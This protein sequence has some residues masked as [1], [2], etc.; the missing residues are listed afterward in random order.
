MKS[1]CVFREDVNS[2]IFSSNYDFN[3][4]TIDCVPTNKFCVKLPKYFYSEFQTPLLF[5]S[6][7]NESFYIMALQ[8][9][10]GLMATN[11]YDVGV[12]VVS[13]DEVNL[14]L[15]NNRSIKPKEVDMSSFNVFNYKKV[16]IGVYKTLVKQFDVE[17]NF[18]F[19]NV[20]EEDKKFLTDTGEV[21]TGLTVLNNVSEHG[22]ISSHIR[23][24]R[25]GYDGILLDDDCIQRRY[26]IKQNKVV[27]YD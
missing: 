21:D 11:F 19:L 15:L 8:A 5:G 26:K 24:W 20:C 27:M 17:Q 7:F 4:G 2:P 14:L 9:T 1:Y 16:P 25:D 10:K 18:C 13:K 22:K 6:P 3:K 12:T 23:A